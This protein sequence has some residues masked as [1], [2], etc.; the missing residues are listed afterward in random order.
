M[1]PNIAIPTLALL[2]AAPAFAQNTGV[3]HPE[4]LNDPVTTTPAAPVER[5]YVKPSP[6]VY[7]SDP[8]APT[9]PTLQT[10]PTPPPTTY[11]AYNPATDTHPAQPMDRSLVVT[12]DPT[13]GVVMDVPAGPN[14]LPAGT[15]LRARLQS[16]ISTKETRSG[17]R[18]TATLSKDVSRNGK[19]FLPSGSTIHGRITEV[20]GGRRI[21]GRAAIRLQANSVTLPDGTAYQLDADVVDLAHF[22]DS[23]VTSEGAIVD[24]DHAKSTIATVGLATGSAAAAGAMIGG[25][26]GA[27]VGAS[28]GAGAG[29]IWWLK[30]D[31]Q[32]TLPTGTE[33]IF[34]LDDV[35]HFNQAP[36]NQ[37]TIQ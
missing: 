19:V 18:F 34:A 32:E 22:K 13:S 26:P 25:V 30:R 21:G 5:H 36:I 20:R 1:K 37:A 28:I 8:A 3:S 2:L 35:V 12:D 33:I 6:D 16:T 24:N 9:T 17:T 11:Q 31:R 15:L 23:H 29:T 10:R 27:V 7:A 14:D 4:D